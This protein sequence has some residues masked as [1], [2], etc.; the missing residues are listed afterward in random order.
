MDFG[1]WSRLPSGQG[2]ALRFKVSHTPIC[3]FLTHP[4]ACTSYSLVFNF[5]SGCHGRF[6]RDSPGRVSLLACFQHSSLISPRPRLCWAGVG[7][8]C[9]GCRRLAPSGVGQ[10]RPLC[11]CLLKLE[12]RARLMIVALGPLWLKC[13]FDSTS[14]RKQ[15]FGLKCTGPVSRETS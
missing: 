1:L 8:C 13:E 11:C 15:C 12:G 7:G 14:S 10:R 4:R 3:P 5:Q 9:L 6:G 2:G